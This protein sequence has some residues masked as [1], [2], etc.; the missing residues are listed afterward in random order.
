MG[1]IDAI[2]EAWELHT[3]KKKARKTAKEE[4]K[5]YDSL[6]DQARDDCDI[7]KLLTYG[8]FKNSIREGAKKIEQSKNPMEIEIRKTGISAMSVAG[9]IAGKK[10]GKD[11]K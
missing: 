8:V 3:V 6:I 11:R 10:V 4:A 2:T 5:R 9:R 1:L 7:G